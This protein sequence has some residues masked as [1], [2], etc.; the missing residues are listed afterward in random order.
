V[1]GCAGFIGSKLVLDW[2]RDPDTRSEKIITLDLLTY[3][4]NLENPNR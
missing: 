4:G 2:S 3:A 1:T